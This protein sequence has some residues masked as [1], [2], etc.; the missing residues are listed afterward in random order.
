MEKQMKDEFP[1]RQD[2]A[3]GP[4]DVAEDREMNQMLL[5]ESTEVERQLL[6]LRAEGLTFAEIAQRLGLSESGV[7]MR[8]RRLKARLG[9]RFNPDFQEPSVESPDTG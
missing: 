2:K 4:S 8:L 1:D 9:K 5:A 6:L 3:P 7:K